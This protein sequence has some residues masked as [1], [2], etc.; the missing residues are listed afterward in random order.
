MA[1]I[2]K[3]GKEVRVPG[4]A[5]PEG[6]R[7]QD[8]LGKLDSMGWREF[9]KMPLADRLG[10]IQIAGLSS[11]FPDRVYMSDRIFDEVTG[12]RKSETVLCVEEIKAFVENRGTKKTITYPVIC[13]LGKEVM[14]QYEK[15]KAE[16]KYIEIVSDVVHRC[17]LR[18]E[19]PAVI[20]DSASL[21]TLIVLPQMLPDY[22][23]VSFGGIK[24]I[25]LKETGKEDGKR[26]IIAMPTQIMSY[27][28][29]IFRIMGKAL[30]YEKGVLK[31][32]GGGFVEITD[33]GVSIKGESEKYG[34]C[35]IDVTKPIDDLLV[36]KLSELIV[37]CHEKGF[38]DLER[39][40]VAVSVQKIH[41]LIYEVVDEFLDKRASELMQAW[42]QKGGELGEIEIKVKGISSK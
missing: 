10:L 23:R 20:S 33:G 26:F 3:G 17:L 6:K 1:L 19:Y 34:A 18:V 22:T 32:I 14:A 40:L 29:D 5:I 25:T 7:R 9:Q 28:E 27:H 13:G 15:A 12:R 31:C 4:R 30:G 8:A 21:M 24:Y 11:E 42:L 39:V 36:E 16:G 41:K 38:A 35:Q 37:L 2:M